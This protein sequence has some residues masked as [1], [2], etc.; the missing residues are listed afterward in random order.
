MDQQE[1]YRQHANSDIWEG[2]GVGRSEEIF[3]SGQASGSTDVRGLREQ[4]VTARLAEA[5]RL[6]QDARKMQDAAERERLIDLQ[7]QIFEKLEK[8]HE[9]SLHLGT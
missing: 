4:A 3:P 1:G 6:A 2:K 7:W 8:E 5:E 9:Q